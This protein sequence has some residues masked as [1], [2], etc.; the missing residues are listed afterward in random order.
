MGTRPFISVVVP[1][2]NSERT[3]KECLESL[4]RLKYPE[5]RRELIVVDGQS[6][7]RTVEIAKDYGA[8]VVIELERK[9]GSTYNR[10]LKEARGKYIAYID[11]D[12]IAPETWLDTAISY[13]EGNF[14]KPANY[15]PMKEH[16]ELKCSLAEVAKY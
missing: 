15:V 3:L 11:S 16:R 14:I 9:R 2:L 7:D 5:D 4:R 13:L 10:G 12:A 8:R 6:E 1:T